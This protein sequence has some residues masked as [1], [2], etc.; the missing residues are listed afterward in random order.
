MPKNNTSLSIEQT[1]CFHNEGV[2]QDGY[3]LDVEPGKTYLLRIL[4]AAL[5]YEYYHKFTVV[6]S[7]PNYVNPYTTDILAISPGETVDA[8]VV[9]DAPPGRYY[10]VALPTKSSLSKVQALTYATRGIVQYSDSHITHGSAEEEKGEPFDN[11][12]PVV[13]EMPDIHDK[14]F[15][16][17]PGQPDQHGPPPS[18]DGAYW[19]RRAPI[20]CAWCGQDIL[21]ASPVMH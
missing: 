21:P 12:V 3:V 20:L 2:A 15:I 4:N 1:V 5:L 6:A 11:R 16:L 10:M 17:L 7:D 18:S 9:A 8:L 19:R 14:M 13:P